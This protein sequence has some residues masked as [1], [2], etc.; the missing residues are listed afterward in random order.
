MVAGGTEE[1]RGAAGCP[2]DDGN[3]IPPQSAA[4]LVLIPCTTCLVPGDTPHGAAACSRSAQARS[5]LESRPDPLPSPTPEV[6]C[7]AYMLSGVIL[8][9][10]TSQP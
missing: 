3:F 10:L 8:R 2:G 4:G 1:V 7:S 9:I 6:I 5:Q